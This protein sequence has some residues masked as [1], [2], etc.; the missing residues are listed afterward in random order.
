MRK[1]LLAA[2]LL[3]APA[4][5]VAQSE[6]EQKCRPVTHDPTYRFCN[7]VAQAI[8][9]AQPRIGLSLAGGNPLP[10]AS[11]TL[12][13]RIGTIPRISLAARASAALMD[14][15]PIDRQGST[16][17]ISAPVPSLNLDASLGVF[18]GFSLLPTVG[19]FASVDL[20]AS[21][22]MIPIPDGEGF[23]DDSP[24]SWAIGARLG[25]LR[26][27][28][29]APGLSVTATYRQIG[30]LAYGDSTFADEK[31]YFRLSDQSV[32]SLRAVVGKRLL[33]LGANA[34]VGYDRFK[35]HAS[36]GVM[37]SALLGTRSDFSGTVENTRK[38][39]FGSVQWTL[40]ILSIVGEGGW[41]T[42]GDPFSAPLPSGQTS[43]REKNG[44][45]GSLAIRLAI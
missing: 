44:Y 13:M 8:D 22:G 11:S 36:F 43:M 30:D 6:L 17:E 23:R 14:L 2:V 38:T 24:K 31:S 20:V 37:S 7:M 29:T 39:V 35:S 26:E 27:S 19:G 25:I 12:G 18:S 9:I 42:G 28:F 33:F 10:G 40:I 5:V 21:A 15:P 34:G 41:Q 1:F 3:A 45:F 32:M 4:I 16:Q